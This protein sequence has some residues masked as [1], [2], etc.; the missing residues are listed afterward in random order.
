MLL[1]KTRY[2]FFLSSHCRALSWPAASSVKEFGGL[3]FWYRPGSRNSPLQF[4][5]LTHFP[6]LRQ[7]LLSLN[8]T[9]CLLLK[10][11]PSVLKWVGYK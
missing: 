1:L 4:I 7:F 9:L 11:F 3:H 5:F 8:Q 6:L 10:L 2:V